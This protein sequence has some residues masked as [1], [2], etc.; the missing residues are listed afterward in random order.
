DRAHRLVEDP[1]TFDE[2]V[3]ALAQAVEVDDPGEV[4]RRLE[5]IELL[6]EQD[7]VRAE[8]DE[9]LAL[10]E[11]LRDHVDLWVNERLAARDRDHRRAALLIVRD[12]LIHRHALHE[13]VYGVLYI[14]EALTVQIAPGTGL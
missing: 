10:E 12:L 3:V 13:C 8:E 1:V 14:P 9:L 5:V 4:R 2:L 11:L 6:L 7:R